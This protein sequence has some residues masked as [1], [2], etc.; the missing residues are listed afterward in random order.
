M[1]KLFTA[2]CFDNLVKAYK[3]RRILNRERNLKNFESFAR[4]KGIIYVNYYDRE[5]Q[6]F[7][8]RKNISTI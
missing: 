8:M 5:T 1:T 2:I 3:Y 4:S 6:K 7:I